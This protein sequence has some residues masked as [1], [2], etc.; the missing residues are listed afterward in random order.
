MLQKRSSCCATRLVMG[1]ELSNGPGRNL[2]CL[3]NLTPLVLC[4]DLNVKFPSWRVQSVSCKLHFK[5]TSSDVYL[6]L[7]QLLCIVAVY[8]YIEGNDLKPLVPK[9]LRLEIRE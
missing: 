4:L 7:E 6:Q 5:A 2:A 8:I 3:I 1:Q 9:P